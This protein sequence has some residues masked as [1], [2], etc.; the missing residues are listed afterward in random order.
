MMQSHV[1]ECMKER[2]LFPLYE[3]PS[4]F[5]PELLHNFVPTVKLM[6]GWIKQRIGAGAD[7]WFSML[8]HA[9]GEIVAMNEKELLEIRDEVTTWLLLNRHLN[10]I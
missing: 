6:E 5:W 9:Y 10:L 4:R 2:N 3:C 1:G 7:I 8:R